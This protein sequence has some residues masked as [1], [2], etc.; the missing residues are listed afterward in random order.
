M[1]TP[2][3]LP[4]EPPLDLD[5]EFTRQVETLI[6][7]GLA[8][9][10]GLAPDAFAALLEPLRAPATALTAGAAIPFVL[11][12]SP[13]L[14]A[15]DEAIVGVQ[16]RDREGFAVMDAEDLARFVA[17]ET[18]TI[19]EGP[20]HLV[21]GLDLGFATRG[22]A[23]T[24]ALATIAAEGRCALTIEEGVALV[25]HFP[26][27]VATNAGFSLVA[28]RCG[29]KRVPALWISKGA[30]KLGWCWAGNPHTWLGTASGAGRAGLA[31]V[32]QA[33]AA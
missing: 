7:R 27:A 15:V 10:A 4:L 11:T 1:S 31:A 26:E 16:R 3:V 29:D 8:E 20:A 24:A 6:D 2:P 17:I 5:A 21:I 25:T 12:L 9:V 28:S 33:A 23:P 22:V 19:P 18:V 32:A 14:V 13:Q 30:P